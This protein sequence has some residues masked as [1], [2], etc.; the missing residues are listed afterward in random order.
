MAGMNKVLL[1]AQTRPMHWQEVD[2]AASTGKQRSKIAV[3]LGG[4]V[5]S[6]TAA[7]VAYLAAQ[8]GSAVIQEGNTIN[9]S[10]G[11]KMHAVTKAQLQNLQAYAIAYGFGAQE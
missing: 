3:P 8:Y 4:E 1:A 11:Y 5:V 10:S 6:M 9:I 7:A 2:E